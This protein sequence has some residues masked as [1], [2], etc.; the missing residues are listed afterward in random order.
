MTEGTPTLFGVF[1]D[2]GHDL[3]PLLGG[4][5]GGS[6]GTGQVCQ[7]HFYVQSRQRVIVHFA[8]AAFPEA[9]RIFTDAQDTGGLSCAISE[10]GHE[11]D[12]GAG[13]ETLL[14]GGSLDEFLQGMTLLVG[15]LDGNRFRSRHG[16]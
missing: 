14:C 1:T 15:D 6:S 11:N 12:P 10:D 3:A 16:R 5:G 4:E 2:Q 13:H 8:P 9:D 7:V